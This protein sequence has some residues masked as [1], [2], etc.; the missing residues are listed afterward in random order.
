MTSG[1]VL[2]LRSVFGCFFMVLLL[3]GCTNSTEDVRDTFCK[4]LALSML[5]QSGDGD[6]AQ[7]D[8][9]FKRPE[10]ATVQVNLKEGGQATCWFGYDD[11]GEE[12]AETHVDPLSAYDTL[13]YAMTLNGKRVDDQ[14]LL[15]AVNAEQ[16]RQ[17]RAAIE[18]LRQAV[19]R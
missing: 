10:Y 18:Q 13:P 14:T 8:H 1:S 19:Y 11:N 16:R 9:Q 4:H 12:T 3:V 6:W 7:T 17:G 2:P 5:G 15:N